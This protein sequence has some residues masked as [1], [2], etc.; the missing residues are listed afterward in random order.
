MDLIVIPLVLYSGFWKTSSRFLE[1][2]KI[3][4]QNFDIIMVTLLSSI[5]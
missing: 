3:K 4:T 1:N 2:N 5:V